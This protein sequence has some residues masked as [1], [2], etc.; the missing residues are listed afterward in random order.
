MIS[1]K[2]GRPLK[3]L[4]I[5]LLD[6]CNFR[7]AYCMPQDLFGEGYPF[8]ASDK[9]LTVDQIALAAEEA[10][11]LGVE[12][13]KLTGGEPLLRPGL[14]EIIRRL[15]A[16]PGLRDLGLV[17][18]GFHL[19]EMGAALRAAGL[20]RVTISLD[21]L[22]PQTF[23]KLNGRPAA[24][25]ERVLAGIHAARNL[26]FDE[27]KVNMVVQRGVNSGEVTRLA[28]Y[29]RGTGVVL[30]FIEY[31]D[32]GIK[33]RYQPELTVPSREI[34]ATLRQRYQLEQAQPHYAGEVAKR[35]IYADG[36]GEVGFI[37]SMT[38][39]FCGACSRLRLSADGKLYACLFAAASLDI[40]P[41]LEAGER[42]ALG[43]ALARFW[44]RRDDRYSELRGTATATGQ[45]IEMYRMGG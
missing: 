9:L 11:A 35:Y 31:M 5:S 34:L 28:D 10:V 17:T 16:I 22:S 4:R 29:F 19:A 21:T 1:D 3:D 33:H 41:L 36:G 39:P 27:I 38:Q 12:K 7:C 14:C 25:H 15:K 37:S 44:R 30:R 42:A 24:E 20:P 32:V 2:L 6:A 43:A 40:R 23:E 8:L 18:N 26:G 13:I 45:K